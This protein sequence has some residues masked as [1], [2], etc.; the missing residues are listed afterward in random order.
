MIELNLLRL[1]EEEE[2]IIYN[3][4][5]NEHLQLCL[6]DIILNSVH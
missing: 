2:I 1:I 6:D 5:I 4:D 3:E